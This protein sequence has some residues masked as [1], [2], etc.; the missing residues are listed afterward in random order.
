MH[1]II[2]AQ[3]RT[4]PTLAPLSICPHCN[5]WVL[6][7]KERSEEQGVIPDVHRASGFRHRSL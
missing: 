7:D 5:S 3:H 4:V 2:R 6:F 1:T